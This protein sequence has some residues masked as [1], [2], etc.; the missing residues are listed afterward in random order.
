MSRELTF[1]LCQYHWA[2][3][4]Q[5]KKPIKCSAPK[6]IDFLMTWVQVDGV[7]I[8]Y[9][10]GSVCYWASWIQILNL[11]IKI[12]IRILPSTSKKLRKTLI[13]TVL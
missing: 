11:F 6:Y 10:S 12:R 5:V 13:S 3:G 1:V 2:D 4:N 7:K 8:L 9:C